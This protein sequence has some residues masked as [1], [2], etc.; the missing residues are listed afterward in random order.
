[1]GRITIVGLG[2]GAKDH[3]TFAVLTELK[4]DK[5]IYLRTEKH[6]TVEF[7]TEE[8]I[9]F[10]SFDYA[11]SE[12]DSFEEVYQHIALALLEEGR[13]KEIVYAVPGHPYVAETTVQHLIKAAEGTDIQIDVL[14][15]MSFLDVLLP[16]LGVDPVDGFKLIDALQLDKQEPDTDSATIITQVYD[17]FVA[18][19]V[20]LR[21]MD[22]YDDEQEIVVVRAAGVPGVEKI[23]KLP[24]Y[25]LDR[26]D[27]IDYLTS[28]YIPRIDMIQKKYYNMNNLGSLMERLRNKDGCPWDI[29]QTHESLKPYLI[30]E[31]Y[32]V[33]E[34]IDL[35]DDYLLEEELGDLLLQVVFHSQIAK[36]RNAFNL[37][38]VIGGIAQ[39]LIFRHPHV[40]KDTRVDNCQEALE[41]WEQQKQ[42][43]KQ[44]KSYTQ[45]MLSVPKQL[46]ALMRA[47]KIQQKAAKVGFDWDDINDV[48]NKIHEE[49]E[50]LKQAHQ[51]GIFDK[52]AEEGGDLLFAVVNLLRFYK[53]EP[54]DAL[55][56][57]ISKF[58]KRFNYIE[59]NAVMAGKKL[60]EMT[61]VE[62]DELWEASKK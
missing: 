56:R 62:M 8:G 54:E 4:K 15:A 36:E 23:E 42:K 29:E 11:Y 46:P 57:T 32:E 41:S 31:S 34:A 7:L 28:L 19:Q 9:S 30:E 13:G 5:E 59:E 33:I 47:N 48:L 45:S 2:P 25:Q 50:E 14:P 58:I 24:L 52:I 10:K 21:L 1:M 44:L 53:V 18:S 40:F 16:V 37:Q 61:L 12:I 51:E 22:Y 39:K 3:L 27:W 60:E 43:E 20:K 55:S 38:D 26:L 49:L 17:T 35:K 6:P